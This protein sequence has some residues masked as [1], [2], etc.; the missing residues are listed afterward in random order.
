MKAFTR[1]AAAL[2]ALVMFAALAA[3]ASADEAKDPPLLALGAGWYDLSGDDS[4]GDFRLEY[5]H[6]P[7]WFG[8]LKPFAGFEVTT[9]GGVWGG[10]GLMID[11]LLTDNIAVS[12]GSGPG[13]YSDGDGRDLGHAVEFRS[14]V[15]VAYVM[16][17]RSRVGLA[18]AHLSNAGLGD[19]NPGVEV[20][21]LYYMLPLNF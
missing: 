5:R 4:A 14:Q 18:F 19:R 12:L 9:D 10:A 2:A 15:E 16:E 11:I 17:D 20:V 7:A 21:T 13:L 6:G 1:S 3:S 8:F